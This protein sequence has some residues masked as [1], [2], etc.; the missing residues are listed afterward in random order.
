[1]R[2]ILNPDTAKALLGFVPKERLLFPNLALD[3]RHVSTPPI[4]ET[5]DGK[6]LL[7]VEEIERG[8]IPGAKLSPDITP[9]YYAPYFSWERPKP[10]VPGKVE[11]AI[12]SA[13]EGGPLEC[14][15]YVT[16]GLALDTGARLSEGADNPWEGGHWRLRSVTQDGVLERFARSGRTV[17]PLAERALDR[18]P[19]AQ[20]FLELFDAGASQERYHSLD[21]LLDRHDAEVLLVTSSL[22]MQDIAGI[23][24]IHPASLPIVVYIKGRREIHVLER[25]E[26]EGGRALRDLFASLRK[27]GAGVAVEDQDATVGQLKALGLDKELPSLRRLSR[28]LRTWRD[29]LS[30]LDVPYY[31][32]AAKITTMAVES[33]LAQLDGTIQRGGKMTETEI[34]KLLEQEY[35]RFFNKL[36]VGF[37]GFVKTAHLNIHAGSRTKVPSL[38]TAY[39]VGPGESSLKI[40]SGVFLVE[41]G[42]FIRAATDMGRTL[43]Y[44]KEGRELYA[45]LHDAVTGAAVPQCRSQATGR[46]VFYAATRGLDAQKER[47]LATG[48]APDAATYTDAYDRYVGHV[49]GKQR[50]V[51]TVFVRQSDYAL[52][53]GISGAIEIP[54]AFDR[55]GL[56]YEDMFIVHPDKGLNLTKH[57]PFPS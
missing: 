33:T 57:H 47:L 22:N 48:L 28:E 15:A 29:E 6:H 12:L 20:S 3:A 54:W 55:Y 24:A 16:A 43:V 27:R 4:V 26:D 30:K 56:Q 1:M 50:F 53:T 25:T 13:A 2:L 45:C 38:P 32:L 52:Q 5:N 7:F 17:R 46:E 11:E 19:D 8:S 51:N 34:A 23:P 41:S 44:G 31:V 37:D 35:D 10:Q 49:V 42:G 14:D 40:D 36:A 18:D 9:V 21:R 39:P